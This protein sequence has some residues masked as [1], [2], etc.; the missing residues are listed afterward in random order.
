LYNGF[1]NLKQHPF[2]L[3]PDPAFIC[4]T[5]QHREAFAGLVYSICT[6]PGLTVLVGEAG[7]GK[8]T[9]LYTLLSLLEKRRFVTAM[10]TNPTLTR[11]EFYDILLAKL[12]VDCSSSLKSRQLM[13]LQDA[14]LRNREAG[15]PSVLIVDEAQRL[16]ADLLEEIRLLLNLETP[17]EKLLQVI[18]AGQPELTEVLRRPELRQLKQRVSCYCKLEPL[19]LQELREYVN[20]RLARAG[21]PRQHLFSETT[22]QVVYEYAHGI[23]RLVNSLCDSALQTGFALQ[24]PA[25]TVAMVREA[26]RDLD[27]SPAGNALGDLPSTLEFAD[28][29]KNGSA[30]GVNTRPAVAS[31]NEW[32]ASPAA[33]ARST[34]SPDGNGGPQMPMETYAARQKSL[35][36]FTDLMSR[37]R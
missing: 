8:T 13:A 18:V 10:C 35:G 25:I 26:A 37:W 3:T 24:A 21:L 9:L 11:E 33:A 4:M 17:S 28:P 29:E 27:L 20:H 16:P 36:F 2:R 31:T 6:R 19:S 23:P 14:L 34:A 7:T 30:N 1:Y 22:L 32:P 12:G 15:R 5:S